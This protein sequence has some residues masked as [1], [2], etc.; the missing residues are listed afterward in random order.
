MKLVEALVYAKE[1][2]AASNIEDSSLEAELLLRHILNFS[3]AQLYSEFNGE[4]GLEQ[5]Q[6]FRKL[7]KRR[8]DGEPSAYITRHR[9]FY[10]LDFYVDRRVLIPRPES[11]LLVEKSLYLARNRTL[12]T[13][14]DIG[15]GSGAIAISL[16][17]NLPG[18]KI[19]ATD[20]SGTALEVARLNAR[21]H[22][23]LSRIS[24]RRG[25]ML[26]PLPEP[27]DL[28]IANLPYVRESELAQTGSLSFEPRRALNGGPTGLEKIERLCRQLNEKLRSSGSLLLEVGL[29]QWEPVDNLLRN[30]F[31]SAQIG[32]FRDLGDIER[33]VSLNLTP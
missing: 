16:A 14:A 10:G 7:I 26:D 15:T 19:Y 33:V 22:G 8:L 6:A 11:E 25:D 12:S 28:V 9:E 24:F 29:G 4:L 27:V 20:M 17:A 30:L 31:P 3:R 1:L 21:R 5:E 13:I 2:L 18:V 32:V 23:I